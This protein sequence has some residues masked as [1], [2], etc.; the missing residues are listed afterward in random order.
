[1]SIQDC[2]VIVNEAYSNSTAKA[3]GYD[4]IE[5]LFSDNSELFNYWGRQF[6]KKFNFLPDQNVLD[7][8]CRDARLTRYLSELFPRTQ[9]TGIESNANYIAEANKLGNDKI[10][11]SSFAEDSKESV[12]GIVSFLHLHK[13]SDKSALIQ[14]ISDTLNDDGVAYLQLC[15]D[16]K[17]PRFDTCIYQT[18]NQPAWLS[19][20]EESVKSNTLITLGDFCGLCQ[21][22][23]LNILEAAIKKY[24]FHFQNEE[25][26]MRWIATW[27]SHVHNIPKKKVKAFLSMCVQYHLKREPKTQ[28]GLIPYTDHVFEV[29]A[30]KQ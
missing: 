20:F 23:G 24:T 27:N 13:V 29:I 4:C 5:S 3:F 26:M 11:I 25:N 30:K 15:G 28:A 17:Q 7:L 9:F 21:K 14:C 1:M 12:D 10:K 22:S 8:G 18:I 16:H 19:Y 6:S 2:S